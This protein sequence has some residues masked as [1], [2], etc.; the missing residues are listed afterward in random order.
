MY[1]QGVM[2]TSMAK[3][4]V[5]EDTSNKN[6]GRLFFVGSE[7]KNPCPFWRLG[8]VFEGIKPLCS[9]NL[10]CR[11][12]KV[13]KEGSYQERLFYCSPHPIESACVFFAWKPDKGTL[14][15]GCVCLFYLPPSTTK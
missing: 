14:E 4:R 13:K 2:C 11:V 12:N 8:D 1:I 10:I 7:R 3:M 15:P 9:H 6:Y 5:V